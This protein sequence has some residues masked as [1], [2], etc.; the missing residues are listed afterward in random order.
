[1]T[2]VLSRRRGL[3][4]AALKYFAAI[5]MLVDHIDMMFLP[6]APLYWYHPLASY[7]L[8]FLGRM[9]LPI[10]AF[11]MAEGM[12]HS[13]NR[14][15]YLIRLGIFGA[16]TQA[17]FLLGFLSGSGS[18]IATFFLAAAGIFAYDKLKTKLPGWISILPL[19]LFAWMAH[20][21]P[22]DYGWAGVLTP[23]CVYLA[24]TRKLQLT[25]L[26]FFMGLQ[27][28]FLS[29]PGFPTAEQWIATIMSWL[30]VL[31]IALLYNGQRGK[32]NKWFFYWFY[33]L[34]LIA[35]GVLSM[36]L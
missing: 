28:L 12:R 22:T 2:A 36:I 1:M 31:L 17:P 11:F 32:A 20:L 33:P 24:R 26:A 6:L 10:F 8:F 23:A 16:A 14:R 9:S 13:R 15:V 4:A 29:G 5:M 3:S 34:H 30:A 35:L 25:V 19:L 27:Y 18:I 7:P 21:L